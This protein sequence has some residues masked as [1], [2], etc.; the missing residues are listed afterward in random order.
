MSE[1]AAYVKNYLA[2]YPGHPDVN[3]FKTVVICSVVGIGTAVGMFYLG[4]NF[5]QQLQRDTV[6]KNN[7]TQGDP[8][9]YATQ[10]KMAFE[11]DNWF[12]WG[13]DNT[14]LFNT[15]LSIPTKKAYSQVQDAYQK[16]YNRAL[17]AD[18]ESELSSNEYNRFILILSRK[19][20]S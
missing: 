8:A 13:T 19:P 12:G 17:N 1:A 4:R 16:L 7:A 20:E 9:A 11:N 2:P 14:L 18:L 6:Q 5:I 15:I 3:E 10:F